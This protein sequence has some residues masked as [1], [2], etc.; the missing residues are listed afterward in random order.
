MMDSLFA[1]MG[2]ERGPRAV[3]SDD[4]GGNDGLGHYRYALE[5]PTGAPGTAM[6]LFALANPS[7]ATHLK[8]DPTVTRCIGYARLWGYG[9]CG[10]VNVRAW[11][12]TVAKKVP[13]D[14]LA[15]GPENDA[16]ILSM[17]RRAGIVVCGWGKLGGIRGRDVLRLLIDAG[18]TPHALALT[19]SGAPGHP[20][21]LLATL[22]PFP[23]DAIRRA[24][25]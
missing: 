6:A 13:A 21:Y 2:L 12:E 3:F 24:G 9:R 5:W 17:A 7:T 10:V 15:I 8:P 11:R 25:T 14:P 20:L 22:K 19:K 23:M 4:G 18:I 16:H 1:A